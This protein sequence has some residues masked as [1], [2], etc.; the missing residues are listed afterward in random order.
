VVAPTSL[1]E[2]GTVCYEVGNKHVP[3]FIQDNQVLIPFEE[4]L[5]RWLSASGYRPVKEMRQLKS[6]LKST[7][8]SNVHTHTHK[9]GDEPLF[10]KIISFASKLPHEK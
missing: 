7:D 5:F 9:H 3:I 1:L 10:T 2:M 4:P 8:A 6:M